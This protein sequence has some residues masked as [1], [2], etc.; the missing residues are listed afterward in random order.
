[1][2]TTDVLLNIQPG[3]AF[4]I[5]AKMMSNDE[6]GLTIRLFGP[7]STAWGRLL[8]GTDDKYNGHMLLPQDQALVTLSRRMRSVSRGDVVVN[9]ISGETMV[10]R[11]VELADDGSYIWYSSLQQKVAY[12]MDD[13]SVIA[14]VSLGGEDQSYSQS[15]GVALPE[16]E[17]TIRIRVPTVT[18]A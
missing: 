4:I 12:T 2:T 5:L 1:M 9:L 18:T 11:D 16:I 3:Q 6:T 13:W 8:V 15:Q 7:N 10:V 17:T 14:H